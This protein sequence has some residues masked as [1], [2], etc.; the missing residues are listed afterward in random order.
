MLPSC[1]GVALG[2][3]LTVASLS[4]VQHQKYTEATLLLVKHIGGEEDI[5]EVKHAAVKPL[6]PF[7]VCHVDDTACG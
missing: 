1:A 6:H 4:Q 2:R 3:L 5:A 7:M